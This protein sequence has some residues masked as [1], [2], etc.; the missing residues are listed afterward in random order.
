MLVDTLCRGQK[1][2]PRAYELLADFA[3]GYIAYALYGTDNDFRLLNVLARLADY[4]FTRVDHHGT[5]TQR[6]AANALGSS[7]NAYDKPLDMAKLLSKKQ[8]FEEFLF[9][10]RPQPTYQEQEQAYLQSLEELYQ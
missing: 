4:E 10:G 7:A 3:A 9:V 8:R 6:L 2:E 5:T 1:V